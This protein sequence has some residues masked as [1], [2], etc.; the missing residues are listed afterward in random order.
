MN[1]GEHTPIDSIFEAIGEHGRADTHTVRRGGGM[2]F[3]LAV[4][5]PYCRKRL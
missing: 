1:G 3:P 5:L 2:V 4:I